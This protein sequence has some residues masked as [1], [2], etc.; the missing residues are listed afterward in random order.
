MAEPARKLLTARQLAERW[1]IS[2]RNA[3]DMIKR[4]PG[5]VVL[6]LGER[7]LYKLPIWVVEKFERAGG[8]EPWR[9]AETQS[10]DASTSEAASGG[11][12]DTTQAASDGTP[13]PSSETK[14][15]PNV[16]RFDSTVKRRIKHTQ[17]GRCRSRQP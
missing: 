5:R 2:E 6:G 15:Q 7:R 17:P 12:G 13:A 9:V 4:L 3:L 8:D 1:G 10:R 11:P 16:L 14:S